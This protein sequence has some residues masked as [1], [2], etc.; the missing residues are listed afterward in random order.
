M[1]TRWNWS[2]VWVIALLLVAASADPELIQET[3]QPTPEASQP[4]PEVGQPTLEGRA[5]DPEPGEPTPEAEAPPAAQAEGEEEPP[6]STRPVPGERRRGMGPVVRV[7]DSYTLRAG[8]RVREVVV[9][10]GSATIEGEVAG[11]VVVVVGTARLAGTSVVGGDFVVVGGS[12]TIESGAV[13]DRDL[14]V[15]GGGLDVPPEFSP[16][17]EQI[18]IGALG[19]AV[20]FDAMVPWFSQGLLWGRPL[21]PSLPWMWAFVGVI[22]LMYLIINI[23]FERP[24]RACSDVLADK[25]LTTG[26]AGFLVLLLI[27]PVS[28]ILMISVVGIV[29]LPFLMLALFIGGVFGRVG[30]VR[31][32]GSRVVA[33]HESGGWGQATRSLTIGF[34]V[35]SL[36]Y[37]MPVIGLVTWAMLG[38]FGLGAATITVVGALRRELPQASQ[39]PPLVVPSTPPAATP[40]DATVEHA[41]ETGAADV[42]IPSGTAGVDT[43]AALL[44]RATFPS[45]VGSVVLDLLLVAITMALLPLEGASVF[46]F[47]VLAYHVVFWGWKGTTIGG[48]ICRLRVVRTDGTPIRFTEAVIRGLSGIFSV[49]ALGIG[50]FWAIGDAERQAWHDKVA[51]TYVVS[52]PPHWPLP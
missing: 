51:G 43:D 15:V 30:V 31:W 16:G 42:T 22:F 4:T 27:G 44:P 11:D 52:V 12:A 3:E 29:V 5:A 18:A 24:V 41:A 40:P 38:V 14:V 26:I 20:P 19:S 46:F 13:V 48:V 6:D 49:A 50:W 39:P 37:V 1:R 17:G 21:V 23:V 34:A 32:M 47:L 10:A 36:A 33:E 8:D 2:W 7:G 45:R 35:V 9:I 25:P 28:L